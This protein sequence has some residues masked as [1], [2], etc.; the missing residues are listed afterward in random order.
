MTTRVPAD[1][2]CL[3]LPDHELCQGEPPPPPAVGGREPDACRFSPLPCF[4]L[5]T[6]FHGLIVVL[7][8]T[9]AVS[10][11]LPT[12][13][14]SIS[15]VQGLGGSSQPAE[16][17]RGGGAPVESAPLPAAEPARAQTAEPKPKK[18]RPLKP[19]Q[20]VHRVPSQEAPKA[21]EKP[22]PPVAH[23]AAAPAVED[24]ADDAQ[25]SGAVSGN[26]SVAAGPFASGAPGGGDSNGVDAGGAVG[27]GG[28]G[29]GSGPI[30]SRFGDADGPRFV[31]RVMPRY[32]ELARRRGR[33]G[34]VVLRLTIDADGTLRDAQI[35]EKAG[36]GFD[37]AALSAARASTYS[38]ARRAGRA[39]DCVSLLPVRFALKEL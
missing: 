16:P 27:G 22:N 13:V 21:V 24:A 34:L 6:L 20:Q 1:P 28:R 4:G 31:E 39:V 18:S 8:L 10:S 15:L 26:G 29:G 30:D 25:R 35:V 38:P 14:I 19:K 33:E 9:L 23:E 11:E 5:A 32:P 36:F 17:G 3:D 2:V 37:E 12:S 7:G